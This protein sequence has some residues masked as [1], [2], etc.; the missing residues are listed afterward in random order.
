MSRGPLTSPRVAETPL[1]ESRLTPY[2]PNLRPI[3]WKWGQSHTRS[4]RFPSHLSQDPPEDDA[5]PA[6]G[7]R[8]VRPCPRIRINPEGSGGATDLGRGGSWSGFGDFYKCPVVP[9]SRE[10]P[11]L[12]Q[13]RVLHEGSATD[14]MC[15]TR[16]EQLGGCSN[17]GSLWDPSLEVLTTGRKGQFQQPIYD[18]GTWDLIRTLTNVEKRTG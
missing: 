15:C 7:S 10:L 6:Y 14:S 5:A 11:S 1:S 8:G 3:T 16:G 2:H 18:I 17:C 12:A 9:G 13:N 4:L